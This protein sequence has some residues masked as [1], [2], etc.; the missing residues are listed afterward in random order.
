HRHRMGDDVYLRVFAPA[1]VRDAIREDLTWGLPGDQLEW[2]DS[3]INGF[4]RTRR[5]NISWHL[6][7][8]STIG[9]AQVAGELNP[10]PD[11]FTWQIFAEGT[12]LFLDGGTLDLGIVRD[13]NLV[14]T[15]DYKMFAETFEGLAKI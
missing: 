9:G 6:D 10:W 3:V 13:G 12:F 5:V 8:A 1:W 2:A 14:S 4:F 7:D 11:T 15:N